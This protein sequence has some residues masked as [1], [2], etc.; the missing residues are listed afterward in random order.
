[1]LK[2]IN[3]QNNKQEAN[4]LNSQIVWASKT[5]KSEF[6]WKFLINTTNF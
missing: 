2:K 3:S 6:G 1:M 4:I 5:P